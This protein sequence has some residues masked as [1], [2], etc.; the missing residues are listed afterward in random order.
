M[1]TQ[2]RIQAASCHSRWHFVS[3]TSQILSGKHS[4]DTA[5][6]RIPYVFFFQLYLWHSKSSAFFQCSNVANLFRSLE[7]SIVLI[8]PRSMDMALTP[9]SLEL[10]LLVCF[11]AFVCANLPRRHL[12]NFAN[13][14]NPT[15]P[16]N[17]N[18]L[19][20]TVDWQPWSSSADHPLLTFLDPAPD[21]S[22]TFDNFRVPEINLLNKIFLQFA[23]GSLDTGS[24]N[25]ALRVN[26]DDRTDTRY[27]LRGEEEL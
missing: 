16:H 3:S 14:G 15:I 12:V 11:Q 18:S 9:T 6:I 22:I 2:A 20:S 21:V 24:M 26:S 27:I 7:R 23:S 5:C 4:R 25:E 10:M 1:N 17:P 19:L 13:T 8:F